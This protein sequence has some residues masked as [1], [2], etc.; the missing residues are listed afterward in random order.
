MFLSPD[1]VLFTKQCTLIGAFP[2]VH[3]SYLYCVL[4]DTKRSG[5]SPQRLYRHKP[6]MS[7][8]NDQSYTYESLASTPMPGVCP[9]IS[10]VISARNVKGRS[11]PQELRRCIRRRPSPA[12]S[13]TTHKLDMEAVYADIC[14]LQTT[15]GRHAK[16]RTRTY[17]SLCS[18][19]IRLRCGPECKAHSTSI[20][21]W[22]FCR[23][24][25]P[26]LDYIDPFFV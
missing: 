18:F 6:P 3:H 8:S 11:S 20:R 21:M 25:T 16:Q 14:T 23:R 26:D 9:T 15:L 2:I 22:S 12:P 10:V 5:I 13:S 4:L 17:K 7:K 1:C 24:R 19:A